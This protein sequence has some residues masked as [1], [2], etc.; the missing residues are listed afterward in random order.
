M[1]IPLYDIFGD[2]LVRQVAVNSVNYKVVSLKGEPYLDIDDKDLRVTFD[3]ASEIASEFESKNRRVIPLTANDK[4]VLEKV[5]RCFNFTP[6]DPVSKVLKN[7]DIEKS[8][9]CTVDNLPSFI[10]PEFYEY[11]RVPG[12]P[13]GRKMQVKADA[14]YVVVAIAGWLLSRIGTARVGQDVIG[15]NV[16]TETKSMLYTTYGNFAGV[17]PETAFIILLAKRVL[18]SN[19]NITSARVY[20]VSDGGG[21]N[22]TVVLGGF[23]VDF[24]RLLEKRELITDELVRLAN[25]ALN[26]DS[27]TNDFSTVVVN[28]AYEVLNGSKEVEELVYFANRYVSMEVASGKFGEFCHDYPAYCTAYYYAQRLLGEVQKA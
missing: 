22:P 4:K 25:D 11:V 5:L 24:T 8:K 9:E 17:K 2:Y 28:K 18:E 12:K 14:R 3:T 26:P 16:F 27:K 10:K 1:I 23:N 20:L 19:S 7:F 6:S 21:Q 15:V 13:G